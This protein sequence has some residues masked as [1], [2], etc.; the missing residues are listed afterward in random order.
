MRTSDVALL[1]DDGFLSITGRIKE[2]F[3]LSNGKYVAPPAIEA[4]FATLCPYASQFMVFGEGKNFAVALLTLD[5]DS[6][7]GWA[8]DHGL[9]GK[10][11]EELTK[12]EAVHD[13]I[14]EDI[15][16]LNASLNRWETIKKWA[17][18]DH[19]LSVEGGQ[20]TPSLKVKR[21]VVAEQNKETLDGFYS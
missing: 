5:E 14:D 4:K 10:P 3:K 21:G 20:L 7:G 6:I 11:Y 16:K 9:D 13:M 17:V 8:K 18:L 19:D 15:K 2:L 12:A 1:D